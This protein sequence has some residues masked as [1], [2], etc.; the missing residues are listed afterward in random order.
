MRRIMPIDHHVDRLTIGKPPRGGIKAFAE[1]GDQSSVEW[2]PF[3]V[4][5]GDEGAGHGSIFYGLSAPGQVLPRRRK[6]V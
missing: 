2:C 4:G 5:D 1:F 6:A 3:R